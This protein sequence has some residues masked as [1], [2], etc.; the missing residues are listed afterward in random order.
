MKRFRITRERISISEAES[1][2]MADFDKLLSA[3]AADSGGSSFLRKY[4]WIILLGL[5][6]VSTYYVV[7]I[8][9]KDDPVSESVIDKKP[10]IEIAPSLP[11]EEEEV[12]LNETNVQSEI[13]KPVEEKLPPEL[14]EDEP[15]A[16]EIENEITTGFEEATPVD[17]FP[18]LYTYFGENLIYPDSIAELEIEGIVMVQF[19]IDATGK[20]SNVQVA[21]PLHPGLDSI[22]ANMVRQMPL[23]YPAKLNG[24]PITST[25][26]IPLQFKVDKQDQD[27]N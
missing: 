14:T 13:E 3:Y 7:S 15:L 12:T 22:A 5:V 8:D 11:I 10:E 1:Q 18:A 4:G 26:R 2:K 19:E 17:G 27:K 6:A 25:H 21:I 24:K 16:K 20:S 23:W 9:V